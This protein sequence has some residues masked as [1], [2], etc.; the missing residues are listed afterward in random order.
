MSVH[1]EL[2][3]EIREVLPLHAD[4]ENAAGQQ[5]YL[6]T[7]EPILGLKIPALRRMVQQIAR[8][9]APGGLPPADLLDTARTLWD[10]ATHREYRRAAILLLLMP[11]HAKMLDSSA[12]ELVEHFVRTGTWWD[13]VDECVHTHNHIRG[14]EGTAAFD[15]EYRRMLV[16]TRD[17]DRWIRRYA[18]LCQLQA[19]QNTSEKLLTQVIEAN[20]ED[21][22]FFVAKAIG[23]ALRDYARNSPGWVLK[24]VAAHP[25]MQPLS[26]REALKRL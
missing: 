12:M 7:T 9:H 14:V 25:G 16:W 4:P 6:K 2:V 15:A 1:Q 21:K 8:K 20:L 22:E 11:G 26:R 17:P 13:L 3:A 24:F 10:Q 23:W 5:K 19:K 18:I